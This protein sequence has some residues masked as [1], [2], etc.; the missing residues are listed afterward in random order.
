[1]I[2]ELRNEHKNKNNVNVGQDQ[3]PKNWRNR[4]TIGDNVDIQQSYGEWYPG[5]VV[6]MKGTKSKKQ[7]KIHYTNY[8]T[9]Y[10]EW[11]PK[12]SQRI[13][14]PQSHGAKTA[15]WRAELQRYDQVEVK[16]G[17][18]WLV[19]EV[20]SVNATKLWVQTACTT[21]DKPHEILRCSDN[22]AKLGTNVA[23][24]NR[25]GS[26]NTMYDAWINL[27]DK[28]H[29]EKSWFDSYDSFCPRGVHSMMLS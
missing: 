26:P 10:D 8:S 24:S 27:M 22:L 18:K 9:H 3:I 11:L 25:H 15:I 12:N 4:V 23:T 2:E 17:K 19:G 7:F 21:H 1:M 13:K 20:T 16:I 6:E 29:Q 5:T 14:F 28:A